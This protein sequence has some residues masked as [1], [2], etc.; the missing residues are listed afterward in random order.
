MLSNKNRGII[1]LPSGNKIK[2]NYDGSKYSFKYRGKTVVVKTIKELDS[3]L[4][5]SKQNTLKK[6]IE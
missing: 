5:R 2:G 6:H 4:T 3:F 1:Q